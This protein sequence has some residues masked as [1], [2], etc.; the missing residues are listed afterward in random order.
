MKPSKKT[1][2]KISPKELE[3]LGENKASVGLKNIKCKGIQ[4]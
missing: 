2:P 1:R 4:S 3:K